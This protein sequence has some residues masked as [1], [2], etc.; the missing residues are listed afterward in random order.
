[1]QLG[2]AGTPAAQ[3]TG[4]IPQLFSRLNH[5]VPIVKQR[6]SDLLC[7]LSETFP[8][9]IIFPA[10]VGSL[11]TG[12]QTSQTLTTIFCTGGGGLEGETGSQAGPVSQEE[13]GQTNQEM[14]SAHARIVEVLKKKSPAAIDQ[15]RT[16]D[17]TLS[18]TDGSER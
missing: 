16:V 15:V 2:M 8:Q 10:V 11:T 6:I 7:R 18:N 1:M 4:I 13:D 9:L 17:E 5:P 14:V 3:W 12:Q